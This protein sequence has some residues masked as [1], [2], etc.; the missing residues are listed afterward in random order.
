ML[1][2]ANQ[3]LRDVFKNELVSFDKFQIELYW[4]VSNIFTFM[5]VWTSS[6]R[7]SL[8]VENDNTENEIFQFG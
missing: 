5:S 4:T 6:N 8:S 1:Q 7:V 3:R 2:E